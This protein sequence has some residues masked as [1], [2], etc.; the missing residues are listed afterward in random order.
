MG[1]TQYQNGTERQTFTFE[2]W[3]KQILRQPSISLLEKQLKA[4]NCWHLFK[5]NTIKSGGIQRFIKHRSNGFE[6]GLE[7]CF[8]F[9]DTPEGHVF[10]SSKVEEYELGE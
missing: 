5:A 10:W 6:K 9:I 7:A 3:K 2:Q 4:D 8:M 1:T